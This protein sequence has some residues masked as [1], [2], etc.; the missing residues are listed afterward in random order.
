MRNLDGKG[1]DV[2]YSHHGCEYCSHTYK[3]RCDYI[4]YSRDIKEVI[5]CIK[6]DRQNS[7][8]VIGLF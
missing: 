5:L 3:H 2:R 1:Y 8:K 6:K 4:Q 7:T